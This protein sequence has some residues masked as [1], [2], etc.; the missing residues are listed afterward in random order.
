MTA[1]SKKYRMTYR[2]CKCEIFKNVDYASG[3]K[4]RFTAEFNFNGKDYVHSLYPCVLEVFKTQLRLQIDTLCNPELFPS[5][6]KEREKRS[7]LISKRWL[8]T[9]KRYKKRS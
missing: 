9:L 1:D 4:L 7:K 3:G 2:G 5:T 6:T 8:K